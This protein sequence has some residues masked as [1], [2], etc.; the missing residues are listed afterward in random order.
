MLGS[1]GGGEPVQGGV[2][3]ALV[4]LV[5]LVCLFGRDRALALIVRVEHLPHLGELAF[6]GLEPG[7]LA[8]RTDSVMP[9]VICAMGGSRSGHPYL[10]FERV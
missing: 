7:S 10:A 6:L 4:A 2:R 5:G 9:C 1:E 3:V 8:R